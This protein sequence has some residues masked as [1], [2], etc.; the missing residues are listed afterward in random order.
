M[1]HILPA[2]CCH[3]VCLFSSRLQWQLRIMSL[4]SLA[5]HQS[6]SFQRFSFLLHPHTQNKKGKWQ[7]A[8]VFISL[9]L[10][11]L[12]DYTK[13]P[14][15]IIQNTSS[16]SPVPC[17]VVLIGLSI[18]LCVLILPV[19]LIQT[20]DWRRQCRGPLGTDTGG[21]ITSLRQKWE[22]SGI[23]SSRCNSIL[24]HNERCL[25]RVLD[26]TT[27]VSFIFWV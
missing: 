22:K 27:E 17:P 20:H 2:S 21:K 26:F 15:F 19:M 12:S 9:N 6:F 8:H 3:W 1:F 18:W 13:I 14:S 16:S 23:W 10:S 5:K 25:Q 24:H 4:Q 7:D 11:P